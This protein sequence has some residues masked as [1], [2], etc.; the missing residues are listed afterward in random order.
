MVPTPGEV[1]KNFCDRMFSEHSTGRI[2]KLLCNDG[3]EN[4]LLLMFVKKTFIKHCQQMLFKCFV[5]TACQTFHD[6]CLRNI[7]SITF[8]S[9]ALFKCLKNVSS[10][11]SVS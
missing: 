7:S 11:Y 8:I 4:Q 10:Q 1:L 5:H 9:S 6:E 2:S 3:Y